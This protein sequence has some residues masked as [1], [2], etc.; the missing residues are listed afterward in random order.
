MLLT[1]KMENKMVDPRDPMIRIKAGKTLLWFGIVSIVMLFAG[2]TSAYLVRQGEGKWVEFA[3]P[4]LFKIST[5][6]IFL[7]SLP[8]H[9]ALKS[10]EK[11]NMK[12][13]KTGLLITFGLGLAFVLCQYLAWSELY[14][15]GIA[16]IGRISD[17]KT[18]FTYIPSGKEKLSEVQDVGNVAGSF[19]YV[20][21][22]LHVVHL[23]AGMAALLVVLVKALRNK[24]SANN[25]N[26]VSMC[27]I[28]WHF[29]DG[30][31]VYLF[32]FLL[33]IR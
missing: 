31:W 17:I 11:G 3:I 32:F 15:N 1:E 22:A 4:N 30:L 21:T 13:L 5:I 28:Y 7:S 2:L 16:F 20:L 19:L 14:D 23:A 29:M 24:Y 25:Y 33:Y 12:N 10:A 8:M 27:A 9:W 26:G 6:I 18:D